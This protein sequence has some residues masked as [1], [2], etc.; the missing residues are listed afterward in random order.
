LAR[1]WGETVDVD[2]AARAVGIVGNEAFERGGGRD[3]V[4][5]AARDTPVQGA[6][7]GLV[8]AN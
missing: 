2:F 1:R 7:D 8:F 6:H 4:E 3:P 5:Q